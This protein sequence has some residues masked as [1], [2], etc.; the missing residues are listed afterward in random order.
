MIQIYTEEALRQVRLPA[1]TE[2]YTPIP[3]GE[4]ID[5]IRRCMIENNLHIVNSFYKISNGGD[6]VIG[7]F[8]FDQDDSEFGGQIAFRNSYDK[9]MSAAIAVGGVVWICSNGMVVG[10]AILK[11]KHTG[12]A[13]DEIFTYTQNAINDYAT[14]HQLILNDSDE[15]K[16][17]K[18]DKSS[19]ARLIGEMYIEQD[20]MTATQL[21]IIK[22]EI[23]FSE[24]FRMINNESSLWDVYNWC[25][26]SYKKSH[27]LNYLQDHINLHTFSQKICQDYKN[28]EISYAESLVI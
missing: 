7:S 25:T 6:K 1:K 9:S 16:S 15:M 18:L 5:T 4:M 3:H 17:I 13:D 14:V 28:A 19:V 21:G 20:L 24:H 26:E 11:R 8:H 10:E 22:R 2:S 27:P 12:H 23:D